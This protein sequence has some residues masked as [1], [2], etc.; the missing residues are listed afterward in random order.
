M[1]ELDFPSY[2][3]QAKHFSEM[4]RVPDYDRFFRDVAFKDSVFEPIESVLFVIDLQQA[5]F[6][7]LSPN[8][9]QVEGYEVD[10]IKAKGPIRY[11]EW[12][13]PMD[14]EL[15]LHKIFA[16]GMKF[17]KKLE[18][19]D[20]SNLRVSYNFRLR[21][22]NGE[23][24]WMYQKFSYM[25]VD[26]ENNPL[27]IMGTLQDISEFQDKEQI[28]CRIYRER[29]ENWEKVFERFFDC[30][31]HTANHPLSSSELEVL[32]FI[33]E[34]LASKQIAS[35]T[36]KSIETIHSQRKS[37]LRKTECAN[38]TEV[39]AKAQREGWFN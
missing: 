16:E 36:G 8:T 26:K 25:S 31:E 38:M 6:L 11:F 35:F 20:L 18:L 34:G 5:S 13:H 7:Y 17:V 32:E 33:R 28:F 12:V 27:V 29:K 22:P 23:Y 39:V 24:R 2:I 30:R 4:A 21:Q 10:E 3:K 37:I 19:T 1:D 14:A 15:I 9:R